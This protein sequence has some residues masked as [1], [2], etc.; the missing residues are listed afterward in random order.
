[1]D[2]IKRLIFKIWLLKNDELAL[3]MMS[4]IEMLNQ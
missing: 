3:N 1:M 2:M 4:Q